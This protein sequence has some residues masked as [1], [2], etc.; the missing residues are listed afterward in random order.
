M[1]KLEEIYDE[2]VNSKITKTEHNAFLK[3]DIKDTKSYHRSTIAAK[4]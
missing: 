3:V 1:D 4:I 2:L